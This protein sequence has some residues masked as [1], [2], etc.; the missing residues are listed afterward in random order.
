MIELARDH[1]NGSIMRMGTQPIALA[2]AALL[3]VLA[4]VAGVSLWRVYGGESPQ[5]GR[6]ATLRQLQARVAQ[7]S[8][9]LVEKTKGIEVTQQES[10]DQLQVLQDQVQAARKQIAAQQADGKRLADQLAALTEAVD[11]LRQSFASAQQPS[12]PSS[13]PH[14]HRSSRA[15][16]HSIRTATQKSA[17]AGG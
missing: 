9:Q 13:P 3:L 14:R 8:E 15:H 2:A 6:A 7:T 12:E 17:K 4:A 10:I 5:L 11:S 1:G 16:V